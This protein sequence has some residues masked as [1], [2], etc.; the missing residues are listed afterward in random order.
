MCFI[1]W[2]NLCVCCAKESHQKKATILTLKT[3]KSRRVVPYKKSLCLWSSYQIEGCFIHLSPLQSFTTPVVS[4]SKLS[5]DSA[6]SYKTLYKTK[7]SRVPRRGPIARTLWIMLVL[8]AFLLP[9]IRATVNLIRYKFMCT[10]AKKDPKLLYTLS[11]IDNTS[12]NKVLDDNPKVFTTRSNHAYSFDS[13]TK[14][15]CA[16]NCANC[17]VWNE[18]E[19][20]EDYRELK[21]K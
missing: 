15:A 20:F 9:T 19:D 5:C 17:H 11:L 18:L 7:L 12:M 2:I 8:L 14:T 1:W 4:K 6:L 21:P 13:D 10:T 16:D 3:S